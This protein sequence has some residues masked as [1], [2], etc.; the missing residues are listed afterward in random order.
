[1][2]AQFLRCQ[3]RSLWLQRCDFGTIENLF[4]STS[5]AQN[6]LV[7]YYRFWEM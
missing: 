2:A 5:V 3:G 1:M 4:S 6:T 7:L